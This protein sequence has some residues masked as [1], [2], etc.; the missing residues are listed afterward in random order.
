MKAKA[1]IITSLLILVFGLG[2][3]LWY[4]KQPQAVACVVENCH[5]LDIQCGAKAPEMCTAMYGLGD[6][7]L[8]YAECGV[9]NGSCQQIE[10]PKF[11]Q[12]KKCA[13]DCQAAS[14]DDP[15]KMFQCDGQCGL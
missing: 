4:F 9:V 5:G 14:P 3:G 7:C 6:K 8:Q 13:Q 2:Y 12:C 15:I 1:V 11:T 10:N